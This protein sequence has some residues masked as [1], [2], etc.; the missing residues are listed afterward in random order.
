MFTE[1]TANTRDAADGFIPDAKRKKA[2]KENADG[3]EAETGGKKD[4]GKRPQQSKTPTDA[5]VGDF[6]DLMSDDK[7]DDKAREILSKL[8]YDDT[9]LSGDEGAEDGNSSEE[10]ESDFDEADYDVYEEG[11]SANGKAK[12]TSSMKNNKRK[13]RAPRKGAKKTSK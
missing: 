11:G 8:G 7:V 1:S 2:K 4:S 3:K 13:R 5:E 9:K 6:S 12:Y 10:S